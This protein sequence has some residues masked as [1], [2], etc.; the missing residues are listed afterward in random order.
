MSGVLP[1]PTAPGQHQLSVT[2]LTQLHVLLE[3]LA[4]QGR[5]PGALQAAHARE[6]GQARQLAAPSIHNAANVYFVS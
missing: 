1:P 4:A 5:V 2:H 6:P 3:V